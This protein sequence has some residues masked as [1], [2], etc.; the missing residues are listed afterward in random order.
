MA[1]ARAISIGLA[2]G[3]YTPYLFT[4][5]LAVSSRSPLSPLVIASQAVCRMSSISLGS[6]VKVPLGLLGEVSWGLLS[7]VIGAGV[8][9]LR[10]LDMYPCDL[11]PL[12]FMCRVLLVLVYV[13]VAS[14]L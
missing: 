9:F 13:V 14:F 12:Y 10:V 3:I 7:M 6:V 2:L 1:R 8:M 4:N 5:L 11:V